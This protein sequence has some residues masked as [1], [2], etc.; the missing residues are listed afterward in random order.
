MSS[1]AFVPVA[2]AADV[3]PDRPRT[4]TVDGREIA[5]FNVDGRFYAID[6]ACPHQGAPLTDGWVAG[7]TVTC[8][9][10]AWCFNLTDGTMTP[11]AFAA[12]DTFDVTVA[13]GEVL[14]RRAPRVRPSAP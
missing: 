3:T 5:V 13:N 7:T 4:V 14:V 1:E 12:I 6:N 11:G 10:H 8:S 9:W 2:R